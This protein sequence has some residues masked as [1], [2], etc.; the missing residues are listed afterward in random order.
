MVFE[1]IKDYHCISI[2]FTLNE[3]N[4]T[5]NYFNFAAL[6][7]KQKVLHMLGKTTLELCPLPS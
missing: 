7:I 5:L 3:K 4:P 6:G 1:S 2:F